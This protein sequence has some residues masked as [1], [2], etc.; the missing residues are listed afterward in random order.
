MANKEEGFVT[1]RLDVVRL[2]KFDLNALAEFEQQMGYTVN[3][4]F[5][6]V[7]EAAAE[8]RLKAATVIGFR[9]VRAL[10]WA[11]LLHENPELTIREAGK[12]ASQGDSTNLPQ[13]IDTLMTKLLE[14]YILFQGPEA[15]KNFDEAR[16]RLEKEAALEMAREAA[17]IG[18]ESSE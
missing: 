11:A 1:I 16:E 8:S 17:G 9:E 5:L 7:K 10:L 6:R 14:A 3:S 12:I 4:L 15:K 18:A 2:L 13:R